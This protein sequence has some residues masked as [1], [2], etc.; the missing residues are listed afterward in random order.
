MAIM[1]KALLLILAIAALVAWRVQVLVVQ[2]QSIKPHWETQ[3]V[4]TNCLGSFFFLL[5]DQLGF[6]LRFSEP[7]KP[8][9][10]DP[11]QVFMETAWFVVS[12]RSNGPDQTLKKR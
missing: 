11:V 7:E 3:P 6:F 10:F 4:K 8:S 2:C 9:S 5:A 12:C 1:A